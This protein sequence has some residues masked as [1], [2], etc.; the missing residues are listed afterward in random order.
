MFKIKNKKLSTAFLILLFII[1][2]LISPY[3]QS[4]ENS[5][6][7][8]WYFPVFIMGMLTAIIFKKNEQKELKPKIIC[9]IDI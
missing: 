6:N 5:I 3:T 7:L 8:R 2:A 1:T 9:D 4:I